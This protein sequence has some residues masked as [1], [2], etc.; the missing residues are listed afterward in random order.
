MEQSDE[1][2]LDFDKDRLA[3]WNPERAQEALRG[4]DAAIYRNHLAIA[5]WIDGWAERLEEDS[6]LASE[7][8]YQNGYINGIREIAAHLRQTDLLPEGV[9]LEGN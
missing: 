1:R 5:Q 2:L 4:D 7:A 6:P 3:D 8:A 9:L